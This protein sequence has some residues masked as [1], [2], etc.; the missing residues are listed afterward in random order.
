MAYINFEDIR[1]V[2]LEPT[3]KCNA[4]CPQCSR[5]IFGGAVDPNLPQVGLT[6]EDM[7]HIFSPELCSNL[8]HVLF[9]GTH[10]D[11]VASEVTVPGAQLLKDRDVEKVWIYTNGSAQG[12]SWWQ[13]LASALSGPQDRVC[14]GIDGLE[15]TNHL[16]RIGTN[17]QKIMSSAEAFINAG[18]NARWEFL[19]FKHNEHQVEEAQ[20]L[21]KKMG[22]KDFRIRKTSRFKPQQH[23]YSIPATPIIEK[24]DREQAVEFSKNFETLFNE[25]YKIKY[26][27][28]PPDNP[29]YKNQAITEEYKDII[30]K[31]GNFKAYANQAPIECIYRGWSR[32]YVSGLAKLWPCCHLASSVLEWKTS[33]FVDD[34]NKKVTDRYG[35]DFN[36]LRTK[37]IKEIL[38]HPWFKEDL[39]ASWQKD[40]YTKDNPRL[41]RCGKTCGKHFNPIL[42]QTEHKNLESN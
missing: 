33:A 10:G 23:G 15:D 9:C 17:W 34:F 1:E 39:T 25:D 30:T 16:Y 20:A 2:H 35:S 29:E 21:A 41:Y 37:S 7:E 36:D 8:I 18:G 14:F 12:K 27:I 4:L 24:M 40:M 5:S 19:V 28:F 3:L 31:F 42:S 11:P 22:F 26:H 6:M 13:D 38:E 32:V